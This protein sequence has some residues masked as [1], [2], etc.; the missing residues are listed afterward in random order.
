MLQQFPFI[1]AIYYTFL[2][3]IPIRTIALHCAHTFLISAITN[4]TDRKREEHQ[5]H[6]RPQSQDKSEQGAEM[7]GENR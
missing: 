1:T 7:Y 6:S 4:L 3:R 5:N 2:V